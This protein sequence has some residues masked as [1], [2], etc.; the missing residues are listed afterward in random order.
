MMAYPP[1]TFNY[2]YNCDLHS[3]VQV[4]ISEFE[5]VFRHE[6]NPSKQLSQLFVQVSVLCNN[7]EVGYAVCTP[8]CPPPDEATKARHKLIHAWKHWLTLP[9][10]YC[11]LSLDAALHLTVWELDMGDP[12]DAVVNCTVVGG[13]LPDNPVFP[14]RLIAE[15]RLPMFCKRGVLKSGTIDVQMHQA[16]EPNPLKNYK[17]TWKFNDNWNDNFDLLLRQVQ[18]QKR[19]LVEDVQWLDPFT[20]KAIETQRAAKKYSSIERNLFLVIEMASITF[21]SK[22]FEVVYY[23]D[24]TKHLRISSSGMVVAGNRVSAADPEIGQDSL[25]EAKHTTMARKNNDPRLKPNKQAKDRLEAIIRLPSSAPLTAEQRDLIWKFQFYLKSDPRALNKYLRCVRWHVPQD[26]KTAL[27]LMNDWAPIQA[28]D[29]LELL[30]PSFT[31]AQVRE[32]AVLRLEEA[33]SPDQVLLY[34]PQLVQALKYEP[35]LATDTSMVV[36]DEQTDSTATREVGVDVPPKSHTDLAKFLVDYATTSSRITNFL[37][38]YLRVEIEA[39][40][41]TDK[42]ASRMY[43]TLMERLLDALK[44][45]PETRAEADKLMEQSAFVAE[46]N[47]LTTEAKARSTKLEQR[48]ADLKK[49]LAASKS[50]NDLKGIPLPLDPTVK[51][52]SVVTES[53]LMFKSQL[54]PVKLSFLSMPST[55]TP[56]D[57]HKEYMVIF[58]QGDDLRQDQLIMQMIRLMDSLFKKEQLDLRLTPYSV[59]ATGVNEGFVQYIKAKPLRIIQAN[60]KEDFF[61]EAMKEARPDPAGPFGIETN[62]VDNF[63]RSLAGYSVICYVLGIGDRHNDNILLCENG[64]VFHVD[65]G[66]ILGRDPKPLPP[67]MKITTEM[68]HAMGGVKSKYFSEFVQHCDSAYRIVR[69]HANVLLNLFSL[70]LDAGI[71][72]IA[73]EPDKAVYKIEQ[74]LRLELSDEEASKHILN[75]IEASMSA[76]MYGFYDRLHDIKQNYF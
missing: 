23:E 64:S 69:R 12:I 36:T 10:R 34:L 39:T 37:Y 41:G 70:M 22:P 20:V 62:V 35:L 28:E 3:E 16:D 49:L 26:K 32:Y 74:R 2:V 38:W 18:R 5:G 29:A 46:L 24:E 25:I 63:V 73:S 17:E 50:M 44:K 40:V 21:D 48:T 31:D 11:D 27:A 1:D 33:A 58:K 66:F 4:K 75:Q 61:R 14:K 65:F 68:V 71:P 59:L 67:P 51:L 52:A 15:S 56:P 72:D 6:R 57:L 8:F 9:I 47:Q 60:F 13:G 55:T 76:R 30:S 7:R 42:T 19:G 43:S 53:L 45:R 54:S